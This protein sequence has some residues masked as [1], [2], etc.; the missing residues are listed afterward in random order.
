ME[1]LDKTIRVV[2]YDPQ[3][4]ILYENEKLRIQH[5]LRDLI[6][7]IEHVGSTAVPNLGAEPIIDIM[8]AVPHLSDA[9]KCVE[10]LQIIGYEYVPEYRDLRSRFFHKGQY[11]KEQHYHLHIVEWT[12][13][14][15]KE[16]LL[17]RDYLRTHA[18]AAKEY[19][20]LKRKLAIKRGLDHDAYTS[21][22]TPFVESVIAKAKLEKEES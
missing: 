3:W 22:K 14:F 18:E 19:Y 21:A 15:W 2:D 8:I 16:H 13:D 9:E 7:G 4:A 20:K 11:P 5:G 10:P 17:F 1:I 6:V 12:S